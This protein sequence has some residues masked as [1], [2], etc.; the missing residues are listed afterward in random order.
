LITSLLSLYTETETEPT[1][2]LP[3]P[4]LTQVHAQVGK[5]GQKHPFFR[6]SS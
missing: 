4:R 5:N 6:F 2:A 1:S 3:S